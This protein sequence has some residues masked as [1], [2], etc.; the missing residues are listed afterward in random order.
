MKELR[1]MVI[2]FDGMLVLFAITRLSFSPHN[3]E[4]R[5]DES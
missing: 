5:I 1:L 4:G 3:N 2:F